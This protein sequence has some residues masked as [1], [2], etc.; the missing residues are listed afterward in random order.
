MKKFKL[1]L[2]LI[3]IIFSPAVSQGIN[4]GEISNYISGSL[5]NLESLYLDLHQSPELSH[6]EFE[7]ARKMGIILDQLG[8]EV[9]RDFGGNSLV[10]VFKNGDG[11]VIML[12]TDMDALPI[13]EKTNLPYASTVTFQTEAGKKVG[14]MHACGHDVHMSVWAGTAKTLINFKDHWKGTLILIAQQAEETSGGASSMIDAG[15]FKKFPTPDYA[16]ALHVDPELQSGTIG[17][18][19]G[20]AFA[21]VSSVDIKIFGEGGH[22]AYPHRCID[23]IVLASRTVLDLQTI[24]SRELSPLN[25][26]VITVGSIHGGT[27]HNIIP[28][29][30]D[31]QLTLRYYKDEVYEHMIK[32][33]NLIT[34]GIAASAGLP[35]EKYPLVINAKENTPPVYNDPE[36]TAKVIGFMQNSI[37]KENTIKIDP[38]MAGEDFGR[39]GRTEEK[40]PIMMFML[41]SVSEQKMKDHKDKGTALPPLHS[42]KFAPDY[43][44]TIETGILVMSTSAIG[45][46][47]E[48]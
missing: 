11:P 12:R 21:G 43:L 6:Y 32:S 44:K 8:F 14:V 40:I 46:F 39:Y 4:T 13:V 37:G 15:L 48:K 36:L 41:G 33:L 18:C 25:P 16:L 17:F 45:L 31:M 29:E 20:P 26:A 35:E 30:V 10:G 27:K 2:I 3:S 22:G 9:T 42:P 1:S 24:V 19:P 7:T 28:D 23:P 5:E 38:L 47:N 34:A